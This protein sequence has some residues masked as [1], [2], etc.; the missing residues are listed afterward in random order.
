[1]ALNGVSWL[2][3]GDGVYDLSCQ[4]EGSQHTAIRADHTW[5][6]WGEQFSKRAFAATISGGGITTIVQGHAAW[7]LDCHEVVDGSLRKAVVY[8]PD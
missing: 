8:A 7:H 3:V 5:L 2:M 6:R 1:M 4:I